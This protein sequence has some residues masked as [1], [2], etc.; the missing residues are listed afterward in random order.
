MDQMWFE[1]GKETDGVKRRVDAK[2]Y[3]R[4]LARTLPALIESE[5]ERARMTLEAERLLSRNKLSPEEI[6][7]L[8]F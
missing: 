8:I 3:G 5:N 2:K 4:L 7:F 6:S 1:S